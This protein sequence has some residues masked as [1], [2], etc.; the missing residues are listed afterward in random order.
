M[1]ASTLIVCPLSVMSNWQA[2][3]RAHIKLLRLNVATYHGPTRKQTAEF[4]QY[5]VVITTYNIVSTEF[6]ENREKS[7]LFSHSWRRVVLDEAHVIRG[8]R[9]QQFQGVCTLTAER[10]WCVTGTPIQNVLEDLYALLAFLRVRP[11]ADHD[12]W[13]KRIALPLKHGDSSGL[14]RLQNVLGAL[15]LRRKKTDKDHLGVPILPPLPTKRVRVWGLPFSG[16]E[17]ALYAKLMASGKAQVE[18]PSFD[19]SSRRMLHF[20][21]E[22]LLR[23]RQCCNHAALVPRKYLQRGFDRNGDEN[24][25]LQELLK[26]G[27]EEC[28]VCLKDRASVCS[29]CCQSLFCSD[30]SKHTEFCPNCGKDLEEYPMIN[31]KEKVTVS[32]EEVNLEKGPF[33]LSPKLK[34]FVDKMKEFQSKDPTFKVVVFSQWTTVLTLIQ[35]T[36]RGEATGHKDFNFKHVR[37]DGSMSHKARQEAINAFQEDKDVRVFIISLSAGGVGLNLTA[38]NKVFMM[39]PWWNPATEDQAIDRVHRLG[40][41]REVEV[42][43]LVMKDSLEE[44][45]MDLQ[46][47]K[48]DMCSTALGGQF[49]KGKSRQEMKAE[50]MAELMALFE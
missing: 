30:C 29:S 40:Q 7:P 1:G 27:S 46:K 24:E 20:V 17:G 12:L 34:F 23:L 33:E 25:R 41:T 2:Q 43:R 47:K 28:C 15:C 10:R 49:R 42:Y 21:L 6:K 3:I 22:M 48:R 32:E 37:L 26:D 11:Y 18:S 31:A 9:T 14:E 13:T 50:R 8:K 5:D 19:T 16:V 45:I 44:R 4:S 38:A 35:R 39:D 36:L